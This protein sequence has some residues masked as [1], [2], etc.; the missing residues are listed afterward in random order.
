[1][2]TQLSSEDH[3][4]PD[5]SKFS[6]ISEKNQEKQFRLKSCLK[7]K[8]QDC[9]MSSNKQVKFLLQDSKGDQRIVHPNDSE[10]DSE[11]NYDSDDSLSYYAI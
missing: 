3:I 8:I 4:S 10:S 11:L 9:S 1:M 2:F 6:L 5:Y 7:L